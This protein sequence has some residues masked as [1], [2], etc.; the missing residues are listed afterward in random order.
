MAGW[1]G[2]GTNLGPI[3]FGGDQSK[4][5]RENI[6][7]P[8][9]AYWLKDKGALNQ[10]EAMAFE[11]GRNTWERYEAWPPRD[12]HSDAQAVHGGRM[13]RCRS[14][15]RA[16]RKCASTA[17]CPIRRIRCRTAIDRFRRPIRP[18]QAGRTGWCRISASSI[19]VR[20]WRAGRPRRLKT[21]LVIA[22]DVKAHLFA[23]TSGSD[24][25]WIVKLIDVYP[26]NDEKLPGYR[27]DDRQRSVS[28][29]IPQQLRASG[30][31]GAGP[32][33]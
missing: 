10:P 12:G 23:S 5:F 26:E 2:E 13:A 22:G 27:I 20:M 4:Y 17:I 7:A 33:V 24:S 19:S 14:M 28:R 3:D 31:A 21:D 18:I 32:R 1:G 30:A 25:D 8:W 9:F 16:M 11:T 15:R 6:E 29:A